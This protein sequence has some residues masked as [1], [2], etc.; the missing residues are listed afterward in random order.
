MAVNREGPIEVGLK[1]RTHP[2]MT[3]TSNL[4]M[5][6]AKASVLTYSAENIQALYMNL[7]NPGCSRIA[8]TPWLAF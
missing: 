4:K 3:V 5:R 8:S 6:L 7:D 1:I 2:A